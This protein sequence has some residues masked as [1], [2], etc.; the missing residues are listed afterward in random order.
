MVVL[1]DGNTLAAFL[2]KTGSSGILKNSGRSSIGGR[3][4][5]DLLLL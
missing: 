2:A 3:R 5:S 1:L 4:G